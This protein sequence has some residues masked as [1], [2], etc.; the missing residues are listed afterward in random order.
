MS[1]YVLKIKE[2]SPVDPDCLMSADG[3][4]LKGAAQVRRPV[5]LDCWVS[6]YV[7]KLRYL[8]AQNMLAIWFNICVVTFYR[9]LNSSLLLFCTVSAARSASTCVC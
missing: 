5:D 8:R 2:L 7:L 1:A 9:S 3:P 6:A 4:K